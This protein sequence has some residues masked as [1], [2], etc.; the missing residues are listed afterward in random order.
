MPGPRA[1]RAVVKPSSK[2]AARAAP[3]KAM[4]FGLHALLTTTFVPGT[5]STTTWLAEPAVPPEHSGWTDPPELYRAQGDT[6][7]GLSG[8]LPAVEVPVVRRAF[9]RDARGGGVGPGATVVDGAPSPASLE[10]T[11]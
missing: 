11:A 9:C 3:K 8:G 4:T 2:P 7:G 1:C 10:L 5:L 6:G